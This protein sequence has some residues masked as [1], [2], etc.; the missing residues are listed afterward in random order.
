MK[1]P[2]GAPVGHRQLASTRS[3]EVSTGKGNSHAAPLQHAPA[4]R[5]WRPLRPPEPPLEPE[6]GAATSSAPATT[7]TSST[8]R[9]RCRCC[10]RR[11]SRSAT[12]SRSAAACCS[13]APSARPSEGI[14]EA[15]KRS[16]QYYINHRWL[17]GTLTNWKTISQSIRRL[18]AA[19]GAAGRRRQGP[20]QEGAAAAHARARQPQ[21]VAGR[22]QG[23]GR[24]ARP[25]VRDRHQQGGDRHR[26]G[27]E[28]RHP[29]RRHRRHQLR[30]RRHRLRRSRATTTPAAP[31]RS[32]ATWSRARPSTASSAARP[33]PASTSARRRRRPPSSCRWT[34]RCS[35]ASRR[36]VARPTT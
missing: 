14:A 33:R 4:A 27:Q 35:R 32:I 24:P 21:Q 1:S 31:S 19:R 28:A 25:A 11:W 36:R 18:Q 10:T 3:A 26:R 8:W 9:R 17:G 7:S 2:A 30:S 5:S 16:A 6:D 12:W 22:H 29:D 34:C 13:S 15:A 23:D 20:H